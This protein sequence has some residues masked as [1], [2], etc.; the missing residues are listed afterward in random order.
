MKI[1]KKGLVILGILSISACSTSEK[2]EL[3]SDKNNSTNSVIESSSLKVDNA[4]PN[5]EEKYNHTINKAEYPKISFEQLRITKGTN[6]L[7]AANYL[8]DEFGINYVE[9]DSSLNPYSFSQPRNQLLDINRENPQLSFLQLFDK[10][11]LLALYKAEEN[12]VYIHPFSMSLS[13]QGSGSFVFS[14]MFK[15]AID[16][17]NLSHYKNKNITKVIKFNYYDGYSIR[18][19]ISAW[20]KESNIASVIWLLQNDEH[21]DFVDEMVETDGSVIDVTPVNIMTKFIESKRKEDA[22]ALTINL[23]HE[24][25]TNRIV[26]HPFDS[27]QPLITFKVNR[28]TVKENLLSMAKLYGY[29]L[30]YDARDYI[31][32]T[33]YITALTNY[34]PRSVNHLIQQYPLESEIIESTKIIKIKDTK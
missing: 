30:Q 12:T 2:L 6:T 4:L 11:G 3:D 18:E 17:E 5:S 15:E 20:A 26:I 27:S 31:I 33:P 13:D 25:A 22:P 9:W 29:D 19:T 16:E 1:L 8:A 7:T 28:T 23:Y 24:T 21:V 14:P 34:I 10:S 32:K